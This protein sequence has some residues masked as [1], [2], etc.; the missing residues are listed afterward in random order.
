MYS[1][2]GG[3]CETI[4]RADTSWFNVYEGF[5]GNYSRITNIAALSMYRGGQVPGWGPDP[6]YPYYNNSY[7]ANGS[8]GTDISQYRASIGWGPAK[9]SNAYYY[10]MTAHPNNTFGDGGTYIDCT[11]LGS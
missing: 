10:K 7:G 4:Y 11:I 2:T 1:I 8:S 5:S 9:E 3:A 6:G